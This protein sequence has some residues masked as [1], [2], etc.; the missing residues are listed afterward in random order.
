MMKNSNNHR[1]TWKYAL[2]TFLIAAVFTLT[3]SEPVRAKAWELIKTIAGINVEE[4]VESPLKGI[5]EENVELYTIPTLA[6]SKAL[7]NPPFQFDLPAWVPEGFVLDQNVAIANSENW[8]MLVWNNSNLS[9][10]QMLVEREYTGYA[11]PAGENSSEEINI[12]GLPALLVRGA[13]DAQHQWDSRLGIVIGWEEDGHFYR[14]TYYERESS[15]N[16]IKPIEG[17][18]DIILNEL[19][20]MAESIQ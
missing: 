10:I 14:L 16:T 8:I 2:L 15:Q 6:L 11:I 4:Q 9:A 5:E 12:N 17:D 1:L 18:M 20:Q 7:E 13:W 3:I 19:I